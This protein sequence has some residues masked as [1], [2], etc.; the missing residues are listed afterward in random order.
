MSIKEF[1]TPDHYLYKPAKILNSIY[2]L[3]DNPHI[4]ICGYNG[5][6]KKTL[7]KPFIGETEKG[8]LLNTFLDYP[9]ETALINI[10]EIE[11]LIEFNDNYMCLDLKN[12][13]NNKDLNLL[14][15]YIIETMTH[16]QY[17]NIYTLVIY[18]AQ[19][20]PINTIN[21]LKNTM[22]TKCVNFRFIFVTNS[23]GKF[24]AP[25][26][27]RTFVINC[28]SPPEINNSRNWHVIK[29]TNK[30]TSEASI[31]SILNKLVLLEKK[32][33][34]SATKKNIATA[35]MSTVTYMEQHTHDDIIITLFEYLIQKKEGSKNLFMISNNIGKYLATNSS[36]FRKI[37]FMILSIL[38]YVQ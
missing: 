24:P 21:A 23:L 31:F 25:F 3:K 37:L 9:D 11:N 10:F 33:R 17:R 4:I 15:N 13:K 27:S 34:E 35:V 22:E 2:K 14:M 18:S 6:G 12:L 16:S 36:Q 7:L 38:F 32:Q 30:T 19:I 20:L 8:K 1:L 29:A 26:I 5:C 28:P